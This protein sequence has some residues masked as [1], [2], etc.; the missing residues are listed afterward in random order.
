VFTKMDLQKLLDGIEL[1]RERSLPDDQLASLF[2]RRL[3]IKEQSPKDIET[4]VLTSRDIIKPLSFEETASK[5]YCNNND[6]DEADIDATIRFSQELASTLAR[7]KNKNSSTVGSPGTPTV[8]DP[9]VEERLSAGDD[10]KTDEEIDP[11]DDDVDEAQAQKRVRLDRKGESRNNTKRRQFSNVGAKK[12]TTLRQVANS[13]K[14]LPIAVTP[15]NEIQKAPAQ[16]SSSASVWKGGQ[17]FIV[18]KGHIMSKEYKR[19]LECKI[20]KMGGTIVEDASEADIIIVEKGLKKELLASEF[21]S[22]KK[23]TVAGDSNYSTKTILNL[24]WL[25]SLILQKQWIDPLSNSSKYVWLD[26]DKAFH[27]EFQDLGSQPV[28]VS[29]SD[30]SNSQHRPSTPTFEEYDGLPQKYRRAIEA[31]DALPT[32]KPN[33]AYRAGATDGNALDQFSVR[34]IPLSSKGP[35][36][37]LASGAALAKASGHGG[38]INVK[39][40]NVPKETLAC[41]K[42]PKMA[43]AEAQALNA[44][45]IEELSKMGDINAAKG[46]TFRAKSYSTAVA[47]I[48]TLDFKLTSSEQIRHRK[49]IGSGMASH[50]DEILA[51]GVFS[52]R[53]EFE[54]D[55]MNVALIKLKDIYGVGEKWAAELYKRGYRDIES[56]RKGLD[57]NDAGLANLTKNQLIGVRH[58][59][60]LLQRMKRPEMEAILNFVKQGT[61]IVYGNVPDLVVEIVGSYRR[62]KESSGDIDII[63]TSPSHMK[64]R[65][66]LLP[67]INYLTKEGLITDTLTMTVSVGEDVKTASPNLE[68]ALEAFHQARGYVG[69]SSSSSSSRINYFVKPANE[70]EPESETF[71]GICLLPKKFPNATGV[72]RRI[73]IKS[74]PAETFAFALLYFTGS[75]HF[76]RSMRYYAKTLGYSLSDKGIYPCTRFGKQTVKGKSILC[77]TEQEVFEVLGLEYRRPQDRNCDEI[78]IVSDSKSAAA[79]QQQPGLDQASEILVDDAVQLDEFME[80]PLSDEDS[81]AGSIIESKLPSYFLH[82]QESID[83]FVVR[84]A[85]SSF[86]V[87]SP[88]IRIWPE[89]VGSGFDELDDNRN[90]MH[91]RKQ[92][93]EKIKT[94][95]NTKETAIALCRQNKALTGKWLI[96]CKREEIDAIWTKICTQVTSPENES[97][98][99]ILGAKVNSIGSRRYKGHYSEI[100]VYTKDFTDVQDLG[101]VLAILRQKLGIVGNLGYKSESMKILLRVDMLFSSKNGME[102]IDKSS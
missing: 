1:E 6:D 51:T 96:S 12:V 54:K 71:M 5:S 25:Q 67:L 14:R 39:Q 4:H 44:Q 55:L 75:A 61:D 89:S 18:A 37:P 46:D 34:I 42:L 81:D 36:S 58:Y 35:D 88:Y 69:A 27:E 22:K 19:N 26:P 80:D 94:N 86:K 7:L 20:M 3:P 82:S 76:N 63:L 98:H 32:L 29:A 31:M 10:I 43:Q 24:D 77:R 17:V 56:I 84:C 73:D 45:L 15:A 72:Y 64:E 68:D 50:I 100:A 101:R 87:R 85:P 11:I 92:W 28:L 38:A 97:K 70:S 48:R 30:S 13:A 78:V 59:E 91:L 23:A 99:W 79:L 57:N 74:Y 41:Q 9:D 52:K 2:L 95:S 62:G 16:T 83:Q 66:S 8:V 93:D 49:G 90:L 47:I 60:D 40:R 33:E 65:L 102:I 53:V 21:K